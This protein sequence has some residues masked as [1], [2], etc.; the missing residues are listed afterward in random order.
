MD[1]RLAQYDEKMQ[2]SY[3]NLLSEFGTIRAGRANPHVL[4][5]IRVDYYGTPSSL[6]QVANVTVPEPRMIQIQ[7]WEAS[8]VKEIEKA[9]MCSDLGIN[10]TND[11]KVIR[12][13]F[14]ELTEE[15]RKDL[16]KD[17]KKKGEQAKVAVRNIRRDGN[18]ALKKLGKTEISEDEIKDLE[19][20]LQKITDKYMAEIDKAV[21]EKSKEILTV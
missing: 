18:D 2:K 5:K 21:D 8:L 16:V 19:N 15:R 11:G 12:L 6:Q 7:P 14:P 3:D 20:Q 10:P 13:V 9:I 17:I 4:D 1:E